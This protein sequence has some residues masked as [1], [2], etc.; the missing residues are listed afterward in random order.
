MVWAAV[1]ILL[2]SPW[3]ITDWLCSTTSTSR[4][5][6]MAATKNS[7]AAANRTTSPT[8]LSSLAAM[9]KR[10]SMTSPDVIQ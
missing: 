3:S 4:R 1:L 6:A 8:R 7:A 10:L 2:F 5:E 9:E